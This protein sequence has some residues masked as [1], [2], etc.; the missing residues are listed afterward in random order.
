VDLLMAVLSVVLQGLK[1]LNSESFS[2][3]GNNKP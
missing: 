1:D 3:N 2:W